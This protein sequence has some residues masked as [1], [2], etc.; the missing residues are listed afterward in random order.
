MRRESIGRLLLGLSTGTVFGFLLHK[1][2]ATEYEK[3]SGQLRLKDPAVIEIMGAASTVGAL[4]TQLL[5]AAGLTENKVKPLNLGGITIGGVLFGTGM[6][7]LGYCPGT[8]LAAVGKGRKDAAA[9]LLGMLGGAFVEGL[10][11]PVL[12][13]DRAGI[14]QFNFLFGQGRCSGA[15]QPKRQCSCLHGH[16]YLSL[17]ATSHCFHCYSPC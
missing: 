16:N 1:S 5:V 14:L 10:A 9:G 7:L 6:A 8:T 12:H 11:A 15:H 2:R 17:N 3:I 4:G 13:L